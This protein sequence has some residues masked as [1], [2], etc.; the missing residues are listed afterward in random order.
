MEATDRYRLTAAN[1]RGGS[2]PP[3]ARIAAGAPLILPRW[4]YAAAL[5]AGLAVLCFSARDQAIDD[6]VKLERLLPKIERAQT[7]SPEA[8]D[9]IARLIARQ[10][11]V[12]GAIDPSQELRRTLAIDRILGALKAKEESATGKSIDRQRNG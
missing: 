2:D 9:A 11:T 3:S 12:G 8:K 4:S 5:V 1:A 6:I 7:L 10:G